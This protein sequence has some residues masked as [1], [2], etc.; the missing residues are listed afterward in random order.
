MKSFLERRDRWGNG[1]SL[2]LLAGAVFLIPLCIGAL[3]HLK[4][5]NDVAGWLPKD[6]PQSKILAWYQEL[7]P[8]A[9][10]ILISW[11]DCNLTDHRLAEIARRLEGIEK[12][13]TR[14]G[15]SVYVSEV[16][17]PSDLLKRMVS[18]G[19]PFETALQRA[20][21]LL[22]GD[23]PLC[24]G[25]TENAK[26]NQT[27]TIAEIMKVAE[28]TLG[29]KPVLTETKFS[30]PSEK[31][32][33]LDDE[34]AYQLNSAIRSWLSVQKPA[35]VRLAWPR[36]HLDSAKT[37]AFR[38]ALTELRVPSANGESVP[39]IR[40]TWH[41]PGAMAAMSVQLSPLGEIDHSRAL[42]EIRAAVIAG[43]VPESSMH[44]GGRPV[45]GT[46]MNEAVKHAAW[47]KQAPVWNLMKRSP[48]LLSVLISVFL[49]YL[50]LKSFRLCVLVQAT[51]I[52]ATVIS[53]ALIPA[54][55]GTMNMVL[56]VMPTL[57][58]VITISGTI[59]I[60]NYW[61]ASGIDDTSK[62][63]MHAVSIA[64]LPC[65]LASA[66]TAIGLASLIVSSLVPVRDFGI[67]AS[68]GCMISFVSITYLLPSM[69]L[70][71]PEKPPRP[72]HI[73]HAGWHQLGRWLARHRTLN[74]GLNL[75]LTVACCWGFAWFRTETKVIRYF[76]DESRVVQDYN[77]LEENLSGIASVDTLVRFNAKQ[78]EE[79]SFLDRARRVFAVQEALRKHPEISGTMSLASFL[80]LESDGS[81]N[82]TSAEKRKSRMREKMIGEKV[83]EK[84]RRHREMAQG[85]ND[86]PTG[87]SIT[88]M[89][90]IA[91]TASDWKTSGDELLNSEGDEIWRITC[92]SSIMSDFDY[93]QLTAELDAIA[94]QELSDLHD[95]KPA[96]VVTGLIPIFLR[97]QQAL[98]ESLINS[99]GM[100]FVLIGIVMV[101]LLRN[102][103][104]AMYSMIPNIQPIALIFGLLGWGDVRVDIGTMITASV[105]LGIAV[106]GTLHL[107]TWFQQLIGQGYSRED[108]VAKSL[109]HCGPAIWQTSA[110]I[111]IGMLTLYPTEL[112][113]ISRFGWIMSG[114]IFA[115]LW[116]DVVLLPSLLAGR[117][118]AILEQIEKRKQS[119]EKSG[120]DGDGSSAL[121]E[122]TPAAPAIVSI[123]EAEKEAAAYVERRDREFPMLRNLRPRP[124]T[125][126]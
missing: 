30:D 4:M 115:A 25:L 17:L 8:E 84:I 7:F 15:G 18:E 119:Q 57:L 54:T 73:N 101:I 97:T 50:M 14:E 92:Q 39:A 29:L 126:Y 78:Q 5:E 89:I 76:A 70:F 49:S 80:K 56:I 98:L 2:W 99:F 91:E 34:D 116:G 109:E 85:D 61:K 110:A 47:N 43:G 20:H 44:L 118:G 113:L 45:A 23:G 58:L 82:S 93:A 83:H 69:M 107:M 48:L 19:I 64:W 33:T 31:Y 104:A 68:I 53:V 122:V 108:A 35:D 3:R 41:I 46:L 42:K 37:D 36:M 88:S 65:F 21:G 63:V 71:W 117:L 125:D 95:G 105:A 103:K 74:Y 100:A 120:G 96:H 60:C 28:K 102:F 87:Q 51:A 52:F 27:E 124:A 123:R 32:L 55:G 106:D 24:I 121:I 9:D 40:E 22:I 94:E 111:G 75:V 112:L 38:R 10:R 86:V 77:F 66:T 79:I 90:V 81:G 6:D 16:S 72:E 59:H 114:L 67:Y 1:Y 12:D 26:A 62:S 11:D 13:G